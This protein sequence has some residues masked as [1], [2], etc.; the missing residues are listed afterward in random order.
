MTGIALGRRFLERMAWIAINLNAQARCFAIE[1]AV[2]GRGGALS[3]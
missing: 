2:F 1:E 3:R